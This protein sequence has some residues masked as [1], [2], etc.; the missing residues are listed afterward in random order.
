[1]NSL[2]KKRLESG[3]ILFAFLGLYLPYIYWEIDDIPL[4]YAGHFG[5]SWT[6]PFKKPLKPK[7][8]L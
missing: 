7:S 8:L 4:Y 3:F 2:H 5:I 6:Y 1:L